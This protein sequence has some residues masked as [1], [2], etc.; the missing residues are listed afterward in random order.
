MLETCGKLRARYFEDYDRVLE[1]ETVDE[2]AQLEHA[3][4]VDLVAADGA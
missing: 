3:R 1:R 2:V 4:R